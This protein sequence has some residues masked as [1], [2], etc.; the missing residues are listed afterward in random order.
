M[1]KKAD[2]NQSLFTA[3]ARALGFHILPIHTIGKGAPDLIV[4]GEMRNHTP[5]EHR[6]YLVELKCNDWTIPP[7]DPRWVNTL[8][9][10]EQ[11]W[12][13]KWRMSPLVIT[14][15]LSWTLRC[16]GWTADQV[17]Q[18]LTRLTDDPGVKSALRAIER[19]D[20]EVSAEIM[21]TIEFD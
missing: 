3:A 17:R 19:R 2:R 10:D 20:G 12:H 15:R 21:A 6:L 9:R 18:A 8:T 13:I 7:T 16:F 11:D 1:P 4:S 5:A 14:N